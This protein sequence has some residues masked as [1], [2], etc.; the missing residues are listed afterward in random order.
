MRRVKCDTMKSVFFSELQA[1][2]E[3]LVT[4]EAVYT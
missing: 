1:K 4:K 2:A 3:I